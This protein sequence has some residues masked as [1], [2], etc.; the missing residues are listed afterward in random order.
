MKLIRKNSY[1][2]L[3]NIS[4]NKYWNDLDPIFRKNLAWFTLVPIKQTIGRLQRGGTD[5]R[6][7]YCD[8]AFAPK[9]A[10]NEIIKRENSMLG[11]WFDI[12]LDGKNDIFIQELYGKFSNG[13][14]KMIHEAN[15][16]LME[17]YGDE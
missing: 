1:R 15:E 2:D 4:Q 8:G 11:E 6:V 9:Y 16:N 7:F 12:L 5:C 10:T 13:L 17:E 3:N 14:E